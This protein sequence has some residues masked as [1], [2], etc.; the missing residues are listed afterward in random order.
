MGMAVCMLILCYVAHELSFDRF[1]A[2]ADRVFSTLQ[3][4]KMGENDLRLNLFAPDF[5]QKVKAANPEVM[6]AVRMTSPVHEQPMVKSEEGRQFI[7]PRFYFADAG[8]FRILSFRFLQGDPASALDAPEAVVLSEP[9]VKKYFGE[10]N[11]I[12]KTL[13]Y[14]KKSL[15]RVTGVFEQLPTNSSLQFD[16]IASSLAFEK[17]WR[18]E[19]AGQNFDAAPIFQTWF[20]LDRAD[21]QGKVEAT[22]PSLLP[23]TGDPVFDNSTYALSPLTEMHL[24]N[25]WGDFS[26]QKY[27]SV[28][29]VV[30][31]LVMF[32][33]LFNYMNL[34]TA[35]AAGRAREVGVRKVLGADAPRLRGQFFGES[36]LVCA[37]GFALGLALFELARP[38]FF[39]M[40]NLEIG[41]AFLRSSL[42]VTVLGGL[43]LAAA[44][45]A[46]IYPAV[47]LARFSPARIL[48][49]DR[50]DGRS[51]E[52]LRRGLMVFQFAVS[53]ALI[54]FSIGIRAQISHM[55]SRDI[56]LNREQVM[57]V[58]MT[59][60]AAAHSQALKQE[61]RAQS[62]VQSVSAASF[63]FFQNGWDMWFVKTPTTQEDVGINAMVVDDHF[64]QT[65]EIQWSTPPAS[66]RDLAP[67]RQLL[68]NESGV[69]KLKIAGNPVGQHLDLD[70][71]REIVGVTRD[72]NFVGLQQK[73][74][75]MLIA[76]APD[77]SAMPGG[78]GHL[79][80]RLTPESDLSSKVA[81][82]GQIFKKYEA[83]SPFEYYFLDEA[84]NDQYRA[85]KCMAWLFSGFTGVAVLLASLGLFGLILYTTE[86]RT[87][88][89]GIRKVLGASVT[90]V[91]TL[92]VRDFVKL[93][94]IAI[95]IASPV[96]CFFMQKWLAD[97]AYRIE[98]Q[99]WMFAAAGVAAAAIALLTVGFQS[100]RAALANPV[101]SLRNE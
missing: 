65:L 36:V 7:E 78:G 74:E 17:T 99:W 83:E 53:T 87:K 8:I 79:Y 64:F 97:F 22:I 40:L 24:G 73:I 35:R 48:K 43:F 45:I 16:F 58:Q 9:M 93:V 39:K 82:I 55:Q 42:F 31:A 72:F 60:N 38:A 41:V 80:V 44:L 67:K 69:E 68:L 21:A 12:G 77:S 92:L 11:P 98:M 57:V 85:E 10:A 28:F 88:E 75:G 66:P 26:N 18:Q 33:A 70:G 49:G 86:R 51:G 4:L 20:L 13:I 76:V 95:V 29:L 2:K 56:G 54:V 19:N 61:I 50:S 27:I 59:K 5:A 25:N 46:G 100:V 71:R 14:N 34:T 84:F 3:K 81:A 62:G 30:A 23:K 52:G 63:G 96:A 32:L 1:H 101:K 89:I 47:L 6:E 90:S 94:I 15:L 37:L 91:T